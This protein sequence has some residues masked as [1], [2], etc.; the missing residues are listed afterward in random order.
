MPSLHMDT[1]EILNDMCVEI[2]VIGKNLNHKFYASESIS[3]DNCL[4]DFD[5]FIRCDLDLINNLMISKLIKPS[6]IVK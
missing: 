1:F 6:T 2:N 4:I 3:N 5:R